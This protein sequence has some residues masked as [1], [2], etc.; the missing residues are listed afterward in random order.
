MRRL[1]DAG[2]RRVVGNTTISPRNVDQVEAIYLQIVALSE[3]AETIG[4]PT[5]VL[6]TFSPWV[7]RPHQARGDGV[8]Q[9]PASS[10][11]QHE[12]LPGLNRS[13]QQVLA[14]TYSRLARDQRRILA[15]S[16]GFTWLHAADNPESQQIIV[17]QDLGFPGGRPEMLNV[18]PAGDVWLDPMFPGPEL[19]VVRSTLGYR[20]REPRIERNPFTQ[21]SDS[22]HSVFPNIIAI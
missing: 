20:D 3:Y 11:L 5:E 14:D 2:V 6:W 22:D 13:L 17:E 21:F 10:G 1:V 9:S 12:D 16:S 19:A 18:N 7:W 8:D 4:S 15:N